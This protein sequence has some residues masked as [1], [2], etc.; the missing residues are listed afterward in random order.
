MLRLY[1]V[2]TAT[3]IKS[4]NWHIKKSKRSDL[5]CVIVLRVQQVAELWQQFRP[6]LQV[7]LGGNG[8]DKDAW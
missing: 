8:G 7:T 2:R 5:A 4:V 1:L 3:G 6:C